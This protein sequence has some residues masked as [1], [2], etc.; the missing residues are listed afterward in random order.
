[1]K[2]FRK[3]VPRSTRIKKEYLTEGPS[4]KH[5]DVVYRMDAN[6]EWHERR[7]VLLSD[8]LC[9]TTVQDELIIEK[10]PLHEI[11]NVLW[12][13]ITDLN[14]NIK[15][16]GEETSSTG[17]RTL[18]GCA[19]FCCRDR[20]LPSGNVLR[21]PAFNVRTYPEG[22]NSGL[23]FTFRATSVESCERWVR[24]LTDAAAVAKR[25]SPKVSFYRR[26]QVAPPAASS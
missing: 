18:G 9:L 5:E 13:E 16:N 23:A 22:T 1:M 26:Y 11:S 6:S 10:I 2:V 8:N 15:L 3:S 7:L 21:S 20:G 14:L 12:L 4:R 24:I 25:T 19:D 17:A